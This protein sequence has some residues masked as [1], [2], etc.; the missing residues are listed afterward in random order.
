MLFIKSI[1][2]YLIFIINSVCT[3][4]GDYK[5]D[6]HSETSTGLVL[7]RQFADDTCPLRLLS[8]SEN[9]HPNTTG[10]IHNFQLSDGTCL[11]RLPI[12]SAEWHT[13]HTIRQ[14]EIVERYCAKSYVYNPDHPD[15]LSPSNFRFVLFHMILQKVV[16]VIRVDLLEIGRAHV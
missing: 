10:P 1:I 14:K 8:N 7:S 13:Y 2:F 11:L 9:V 4:S 3:Y 16:G 6:N 15:E 12:S 5:D